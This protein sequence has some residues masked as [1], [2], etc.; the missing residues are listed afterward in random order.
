MIQLKKNYITHRTGEG[1]V[2]LAV[3]KEANDFHKVVKLNGTAAEIVNL[4]AAPTTE[5]TIVSVLAGTYHDEDRTLIA[6]DVKEVLE[7]LRNLNVLDEHD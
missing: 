2:L 4:L 1:A 7:T 6:S 3:G 5:E